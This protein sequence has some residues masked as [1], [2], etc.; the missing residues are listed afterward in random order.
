MPSCITGG[1]WPLPSLGSF[2]VPRVSF[3]SLQM[4]MS[5]IYLADISPKYGRCPLRF[6]FLSAEV[7]DGVKVLG[8]NCTTVI[9]VQFLS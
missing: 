6:S 9:L 4:L 7:S 5:A 2:R 8:G 3:I 1:R